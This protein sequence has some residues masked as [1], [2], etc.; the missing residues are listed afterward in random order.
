MRAAQA[1]RDRTLDLL[2]AAYGEGRLDEAEHQQRT[3]MVLR[4]KTYGELSQLVADLP[5]GPM[6]MPP[7]QAAPTLGPTQ[8]V[9]GTFRPLPPPAKTNSMAVGSLICGLVQPF[10]FGASAIPAIILGHASKS[11][12]RTS[13]EEG[14]GMATAGLVL[15]WLG[16][17]FWLMVAFFALVVPG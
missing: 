1:D 6:G 14:D 4:A 10:T 7:M 8:A 2:R 17:A 15:G 12:I 13:G 16:V 9:P 11:Q 5:Q 3:E